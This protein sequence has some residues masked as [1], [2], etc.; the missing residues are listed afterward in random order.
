M[1]L[2][3]WAMVRSFRAS[4]RSRC[5][6]TVFSSAVLLVQWVSAWASCG[7]TPY[8]FTRAHTISQSPPSAMGVVNSQSTSRLSSG[9][10]AVATACSRHQAA[11]SSLLKNAR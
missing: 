3:S 6:S 1:S 5:E 2:S 4:W 11:R 7:T 9:L 10:S 8:F